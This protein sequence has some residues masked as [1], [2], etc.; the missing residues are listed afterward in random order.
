M[1]SRAVRSISKPAPSSM[2]GAMVPFTV[3]L[4]LLGLYTPAMVL[5]RVDLPEP[6][7]PTRP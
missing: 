7:K 2:S 6:F 1:F 4:P 5:S 3:T